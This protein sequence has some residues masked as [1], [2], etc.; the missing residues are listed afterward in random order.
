MTD[1]ELKD[2]ISKVNT[3]KKLKNELRNTLDIISII[4]QSNKNYGSDQA[5]RVGNSVLNWIADNEEEYTVF[6][7]FV[8][9]HKEQIEETLDN[10]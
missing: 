6:F 9:N 3:A 1:E 5:Y 10:L 4:T 7:N 8:T 2:L